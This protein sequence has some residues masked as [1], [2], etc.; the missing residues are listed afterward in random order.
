M[1]APLASG[2]PAVG[3]TWMFCQ[4][5]VLGLKMP[6]LAAVMVTVNVLEAT[7]TGIVLLLARSLMLR[8]AVLPPFTFTVT[9][10]LVLKANPLGAVN[11]I[12]PV[13]IAP[14][15]L[16]V[17]TGPVSVVHALP[18]FV[19]EMAEPPVAAVMVVVEANARCAPASARTQITARTAV[20]FRRINI[21]CVALPKS[22]NSSFYPVSLSHHGIATTEVGP[23]HGPGELLT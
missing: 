1:R 8:E 18:A 3:R 4:V 20:F 5:R 6:E 23:N 12:V 7:V 21:V 22:V 17:R 13:P 14:E 15:L 2:V 10:A 11:M 16:S 19:A 9:V